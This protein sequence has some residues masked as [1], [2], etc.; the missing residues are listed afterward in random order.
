MAGMGETLH[1]RE[2]FSFIAA[3]LMDQSLKRI[4]CRRESNYRFCFNT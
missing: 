4:S 2:G 1:E 3:V